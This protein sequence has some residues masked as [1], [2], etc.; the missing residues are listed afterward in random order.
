[1]TCADDH[2]VDCISRLALDFDLAE[3][4]SGVDNVKKLY[5]GS[6]IEGQTTTLPLDVTIYKI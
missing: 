2:F 5:T 6:D 4:Y 1:M 3:H